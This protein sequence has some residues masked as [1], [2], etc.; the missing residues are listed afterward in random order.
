MSICIRWTERPDGV[1]GKAYEQ[2]MSVIEGWL[3]RKDHEHFAGYVA[4]WP[5]VDLAEKIAAKLL[6]ERGYDEALLEAAID[7]DW[8]K[9]WSPGDLDAELERTR[10]RAP[11]PA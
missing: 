11:E 9:G 7:G 10:R 5:G 6:S 1:V 4:G 8:P 3:N 2:A